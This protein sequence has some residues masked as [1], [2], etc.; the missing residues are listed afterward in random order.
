[1]SLLEDAFESLMDLLVDVVGLSYILEDVATLLLWK[2]LSHHSLSCLELEACHIPEHINNK[3][4]WDAVFHLTFYFC[5]D[6]HERFCIR[7]FQLLLYL[8]QFHQV[9]NKKLLLFH[10]ADRLG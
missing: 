8:K 9:S 7:L 6:I 3:R 10:L 2:G 1:M 5:K 4:S